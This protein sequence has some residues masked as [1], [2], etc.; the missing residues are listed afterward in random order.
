MSD[1]KQELPAVWDAEAV[2]K[3]LPAFAKAIQD[4]KPVLDAKLKECDTD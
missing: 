4:N 2:K 3:T 1:W